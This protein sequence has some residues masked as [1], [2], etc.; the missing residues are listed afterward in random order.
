MAKP[1]K[2]P[3]KTKKVDKKEEKPKSYAVNI[4]HTLSCR[5]TRHADH[6]DEWDAD[7]LAY[8]PEVQAVQLSGSEY[9]DFYLDSEPKVGEN[10][11]LVYVIYSTGD[12]FHHEEGR[13]EFVGLLKDAVDAE[14]LAEHIRKSDGSLT[15]YQVALPSGESIEYYNGA[16]TGYFESLTSVN[17]ASIPVTYCKTF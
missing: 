3:I 9:G 17:V 2:K 1:K 7:D 10:F 16:W 5:V 13:I 8:Q 15:R 14:A 12:S 6:T 11:F 4:L